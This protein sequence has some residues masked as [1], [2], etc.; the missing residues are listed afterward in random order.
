LT[1]CGIDLFVY[2]TLHNNY[3]RNKIYGLIPYH[4]NTISKVFKII[5]GQGASW[6]YYNLSSPYT[7]T[8]ER[9]PLSITSKRTGQLCR[10]CLWNRYQCPEKTN[11]ITLNKIFP[12]NLY[13][14]LMLKNCL[15]QCET[16]FTKCV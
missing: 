9:V 12:K 2:C 14:I 11:K 15:S 13:T 16:E 5:Y 1:I 6:Q 10:L 7:H 8:T 4:Y 3:M